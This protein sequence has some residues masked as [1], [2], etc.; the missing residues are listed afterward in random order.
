MAHTP[1]LANVASTNT[2]SA[3]SATTTTASLAPTAGHQGWFAVTAA[4]HAATPFTDTTTFSGWGLTWTKVDAVISGNYILTVWQG[5]G[6]P[7]TGAF[8][9]VHSQ[10][11]ASG[12]WA[13][14]GIPTFA[15]ATTTSGGTRDPYLAGTVAKA[16]GSGTTGTVTLATDGDEPGGRSWSFFVHATAEVSSPDATDWAWTELDDANATSIAL[17]VQCVLAGGV[18][19]TATATWAT[20]SAWLGIHLVQQAPGSA[21][22]LVDAGNIRSGGLSG[23]GG[24][25]AGSEVEAPGV[26]GWSG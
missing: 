15:D 17:Q 16:S 20:S 2:L 6:T 26:W 4:R 19:T 10:I 21:A 14:F 1:A 18:D 24:T 25:L 13:V 7:A 8:T 9:I 11:P 23:Y 12:R 22:A 3:V 5:K